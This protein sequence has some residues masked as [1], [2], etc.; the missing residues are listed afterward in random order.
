VPMWRADAGNNGLH[1]GT[2]S[3]FEAL[4][5]TVSAGV[6]Y[7]P[8]T[9][10]FT[11]AVAAL[12]SAVRG[13]RNERPAAHVAVYLASFEEAVDIFRLAR[14]DPDLAAIRWYGADGVSQSR[15]LIA[16]ANAAAFAVATSFTAP[17]VG[18]DDAA[19][20]Q[21]QPVSDEIRRRIGFDPDAYAL[22][23]YDAAWV[24]TLSTI[25]AGNDPTLLRESFVRNVQRYWGLTG[26][27]ALDAAGDRKIGTFVFWTVRNINGTI[28]WV[29][30]K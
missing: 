14:L 10:D 1:D 27:T 18:L 26:P 24:A 4:G 22:S 29:R 20:D 3:A 7:A 8:T 2:K 17:N 9:T 21:W 6:P 19:R 16:D 12:G 15:A 23:V 11:T 5:G 30:T 25:E 13:V 28:D